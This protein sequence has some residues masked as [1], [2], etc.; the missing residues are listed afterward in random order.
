MNEKKPRRPGSILAFSTLGL[1]LTLAGCQSPG[2]PVAVVTRAPETGAVVTR[3]YLYVVNTHGD[4]V[5]AWSINT[6]SGALT[7]VDGSPFPTG[8]GPAGM[9]V[10]PAG[11]F[12]FVAAHAGNTVSGWAISPANG[13][14][15]PLEGSPFAAGNGPTGVAVDPA[16]KVLL[17]TNDSGNN[18]SAWAIAGGGTLAPLA[19]SPFR[20][21][22]HP[23]GV[24]ADRA[25][26]RLY[27]VNNGSNDISTYV[28][29]TGNGTATVAR[30]PASSAGNY[31]A[32]VTTAPAPPIQKFRPPDN[33]A[34]RP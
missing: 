4:S 9:A 28:I 5:S 34:H 27:V 19:D 12:L 1:L 17:V 11:R 23:A 22:S 29:R 25:G 2:K 20:T 3:Y 26:R 24:A 13:A 31:P 32:G 18:M 21:G 14:L 8:K 15:A 7:P 6:A 16:G 10:D 33:T 30:G